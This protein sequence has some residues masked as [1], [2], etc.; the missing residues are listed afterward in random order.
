MLESIWC[1][2]LTASGLA[3]G[4]CEGQLYSMPVH[5]PTEV[6]AAVTLCW[7]VPTL[8]VALGD[9]ASCGGNTHETLALDDGMH[10]TEVN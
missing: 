5:T 6:D 4:T 8:A 2:F 1:S 3:M 9:V 10:Q 7:S